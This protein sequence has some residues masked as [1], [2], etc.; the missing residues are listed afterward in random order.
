M[1]VEHVVEADLAGHAPARGDGGVVV[2]GVDAREASAADAKRRAGHDGERPGLGV[3]ARAPIGREVHADAEIRLKGAEIGE[4]ILQQKGRREHP[5]MGELGL[6][7]AGA[8]DVS[9]RDAADGFNRPILGDV[10][11]DVERRNNRP[12]RARARARDDGIEAAG[13][14]RRYAEA[15]AIREGRINGASVVNRA[16]ASRRNHAANLQAN[17]EGLVSVHERRRRRRRR[18]GR[19]V[20]GKA[21][22]ARGAQKCSGESATNNGFHRI[23]LKRLSNDTVPKLASSPL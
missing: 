7:R 9:R 16:F 19:K 2:L 13:E 18:R 3:D 20:G 4:V 8:L 21:G 15:A 5:G 22:S 6:D 17:L 14:T 23:P 1:F 12:A 10:V 11:G